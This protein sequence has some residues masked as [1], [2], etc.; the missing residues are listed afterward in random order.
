MQNTP[1]RLHH[2]HHKIDT[3]SIK[4]FKRTDWNVADM[5]RI[6]NVLQDK[7]LVHLTLKNTAP[8]P[9]LRFLYGATSGQRGIWDS[10]T[11]WTAHTL[12]DSAGCQRVCACRQGLQPCWSRSE[13]SAWRQTGSDRQQHRGW[14]FSRPV[15]S[16]LAYPLSSLSPSVCPAVCPSTEI[17]VDLNSN[18]ASHSGLPFPCCSSQFS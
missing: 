6:W 14:S 13:I 5:L 18:A 4:S 16:T 9:G 3:A 11:V 12:T 17:S 7:Q 2:I 10:S 15:S 8:K 1:F